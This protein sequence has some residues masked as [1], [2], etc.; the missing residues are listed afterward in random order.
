MFMG[1]RHKAMLKLG[2]GDRLTRGVYKYLSNHAHS[3]SMA[4]HRTAVNGLYEKD[5]AASKAVAGFATQFARMALGTACI[6][7][8][9]LFPDA[10]SALD[11]V[12]V[13]ALKAT[14]TPAAD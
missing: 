8:F 3:Q 4:F 14:Y 2:W 1:G 12:L 10:E 6:H 7:M 5:S 13:D 11:P 9:S